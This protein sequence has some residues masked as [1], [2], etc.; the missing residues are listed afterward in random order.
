MV[1]VQT[2]D[3]Q[4]VFP[5]GNIISSIKG[6][7]AR[8]K[9]WIPIVNRLLH[10]FLLLDNWISNGRST[11]FKAIGNDWPAIVGA[12][13]DKIELITA[14]WAKLVAPKLTGFRME[15]KALWVSM[16]IGINLRSRIRIPFKRISRNRPS[17]LIDPD[18]RA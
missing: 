8:G 17:L 12:S 3:K 7:P 10:S 11:I 9:H 4:A 15:S 14:E 18:N 1:A 2:C 6:H 13:F 16:S 5:F